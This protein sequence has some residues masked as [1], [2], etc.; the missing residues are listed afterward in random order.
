MQLGEY[1]RGI[2]IQSIATATSWAVPLDPKTLK[3]K[4]K[5]GSNNNKTLIEDRFLIKAIRYQIISKTGKIIYL[6]KF[7]GV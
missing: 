1:M 6:S 7:K 4:L 5:R 2:I 3:E